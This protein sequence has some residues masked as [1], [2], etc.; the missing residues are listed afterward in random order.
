VVELLVVWKAPDVVGKFV[1][2]ATPETY[3]LPPESIAIAVA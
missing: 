3:A 1:D 2:P